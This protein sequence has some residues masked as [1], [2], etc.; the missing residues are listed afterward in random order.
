MSLI[1]S[2]TAAP[3]AAAEQ[4][5]SIG[6]VSIGVQA[7]ILAALRSQGQN[8]PGIRI[9]NVMARFREMSPH[10]SLNDSQLAAVIVEAAM[11]LGLTTL[12]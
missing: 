1:A 10:S 7:A 5:V 8:R 9:E 4:P 6:P 12:K 11:V 2:L 3:S